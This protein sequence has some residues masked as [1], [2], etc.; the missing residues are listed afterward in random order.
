MKNM[1]LSIVLLSFFSFSSYAQESI[2]TSEATGHK[3]ITAL[4][5][6]FGM[7]KQKVK[8]LCSKNKL[9]LSYSDNDSLV[10][11]GSLT[12]ISEID[13]TFLIFYKNQLAK[14]VAALNVDTTD[15]SANHL[16]STYNR[17]KNML[18]EKY[19]PPKKSLEF[20]DDNYDNSDYRLVGLKTGEGVYS[21]TWELEDLS[22][23]L[24]LGGDNFRVEFTLVY[25]Y[26]PLFNKFTEERETK[27]KEEL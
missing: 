6:T 13:K 16:L 10:Y 24:R 27:Q 21:S 11:S 23:Y 26:A 1:I 2:K 18:I 19:G 5:F 22:I 14:L 15:S 25:E 9:I 12:S 3:S 4:G 8:S 7:T 20:M 17:I